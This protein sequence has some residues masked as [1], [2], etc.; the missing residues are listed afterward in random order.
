MDGAMGVSCV[1][2]Q[3]ERYELQHS[4]LN[5]YADSGLMMDRRVFPRQVSRNG[6]S[7][8]TD[9]LISMTVCPDVIFLQI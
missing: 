6:R 2:P 9:S 7:K 5:G 4:V 3:R 1:T 8:E